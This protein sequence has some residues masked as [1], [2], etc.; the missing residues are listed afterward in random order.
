MAWSLSPKVWDA[1]VSCAAGQGVG[2]FIPAIGF[3]FDAFGGTEILAGIC[4]QAIR[5]RRRS[6]ISNQFT[7]IWRVR[8]GRFCPGLDISAVG[9]TAIAAPAYL[10]LP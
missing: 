6:L 9:T 4:L 10:R 1:A 8:D 2:Q 7:W 3:F 5:R